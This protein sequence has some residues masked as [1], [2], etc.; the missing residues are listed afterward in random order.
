MRQ[1]TALYRFFTDDGRLLYVGISNSFPNR[2]MQHEAEKPWWQDVARVEVEHFA[3]RAEALAAETAAINA[4]CPFWNIVGQPLVD[5]LDRV[6]HF[7]PRFAD[8]LTEVRCMQPDHFDPGWCPDGMWFFGDPGL[9]NSGIYSRLKVLVGENR[10]TDEDDY[11]RR[12]PVIRD[13]RERPLGNRYR[14]PEGLFTVDEFIDLMEEQEPEPRRSSVEAWLR[15]HPL[16][17]KVVERVWALMPGHQSDAVSCQSCGW[18]R[19]EV[20]A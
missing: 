19:Q 4:E 16:F 8:L 6:A 9:A 3:S 11:D 13:E 2:L 1:H 20:P 15:S 7:E 12:L 10:Y 18:A 14:R 5:V 17:L